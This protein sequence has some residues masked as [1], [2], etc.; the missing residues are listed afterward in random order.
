MPL[1]ELPLY[2]SLS[3]ALLLLPRLGY[4]TLSELTRYANFLPCV[5][6]G[7]RGIPLSIFNFPL[8]TIHRL[9]QLL[10]NDPVGHDD[11]VRSV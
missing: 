8:S 7:G 9:L 5:E 6:G 4:S 1:C 3:V 11:M 2:G 10:M